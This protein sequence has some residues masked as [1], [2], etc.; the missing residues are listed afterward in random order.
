M[1]WIAGAWCFASTPILGVVKARVGFRFFTSRRG[2][3]TPSIGVLS[4][5]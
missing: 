2:T 3:S 4:P 1:F 5:R